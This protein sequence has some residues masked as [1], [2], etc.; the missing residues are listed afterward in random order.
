MSKVKQFIEKYKQWEETKPVLNVE[1]TYTISKLATKDG[2]GYKIGDNMLFEVA[3][4]DNEGNLIPYYYKL[5]P[6]EVLG[7]IKWLREWYE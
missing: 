6:N 4:I 1:N 7:F 3:K 5:T 2:L